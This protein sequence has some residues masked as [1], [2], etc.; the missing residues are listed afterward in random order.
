MRTLIHTCTWMLLAGFA[1][2]GSTEARADCEDRLEEFKEQGDRARYYPDEMRHDLRQL[3]DSAELLLETD[4]EDLCND[5]VDAMQ[6]TMEKYSAEVEK[7]QRK[8]QLENAAPVAQVPGIMRTSSIEG[9]VIRSSDGGKL[10]TIED[11]VLTPGSG[12]VAYV[13]MSYGGFL[14]IGTKLIAVPWDA[15]RV[16]DKSAFVL[17]IDEE[18][19]DE[20]EGFDDDEWPSQGNAKLRTGSR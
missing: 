13:A 16:T 11:V 2:L 5:V 4:R 1:G 10:G 19:L 14:G 20:L 8:V 17:G 3:R 18:A 6:D 15:L 12:Q 7:A 9:S